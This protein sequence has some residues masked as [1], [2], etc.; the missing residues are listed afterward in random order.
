[1]EI[2]LVII[3]VGLAAVYLGKTFYRT[4]RSTQEGSPACNCGSCGDHA[5][6]CDT[7]S[8]VAI[9]EQCGECASR[10]EKPGVD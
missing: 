4:Y 7:G 1:M 5:G 3:I 2:V 6:S 10:E 9:A 8:P